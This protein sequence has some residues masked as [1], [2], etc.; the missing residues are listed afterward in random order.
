MRSHDDGA[1]RFDRKRCVGRRTQAT[2]GSATSNIWYSL[3]KRSSQATLSRWRTVT[4][5]RNTTSAFWGVKAMSG[6]VSYKTHILI[7]VRSNGVMTVIADWPHVPKQAEVQKEIDATSNGYVAFALC[8]PTS[9]LSGNGN[10]NARGG[11]HRPVGPG[12]R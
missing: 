6:D 8:T 9:I 5:T 11:W 2:R 4:S 12:R 7:G 10:G 3:A 1:A